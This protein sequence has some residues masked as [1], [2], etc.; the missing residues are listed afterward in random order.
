MRETLLDRARH[1]ARENEQWARE[2]LARWRAA[3]CPEPDGLT[4]LAQRIMARHEA[5]EPQPSL[6][7]EVV[8][9]E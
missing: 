3:G 6:F 4:Q 2:H 7:A 8:A 9:D 5:Q 1:H